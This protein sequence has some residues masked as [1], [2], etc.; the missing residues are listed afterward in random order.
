MKLVAMSQ[1]AA[2]HNEVAQRLKPSSSKVSTFAAL[3]IITIIGRA[4]GT[5]RTVA[6]GCTTCSEHT[7]N[8]QTRRVK[9]EPRYAFGKDTQSAWR[10]IP[11][12]SLWLIRIKRD[13]QTKKQ[14]RKHSFKT[15][16]A[17]K[18]DPKIKPPKHFPIFSNSEHL[19]QKQ[20][21]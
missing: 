10:P 19:A 17:S 21:A 2:C 1:S 15:K 18:F 16:S 3:P 13:E 4:I 11:T 9:R 8:P 7:L 5:S 14:S 12:V 20:T 6:N